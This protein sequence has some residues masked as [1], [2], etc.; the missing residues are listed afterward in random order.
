[1]PIDSTTIITRLILYVPT[2]GSGIAAGGI[3]AR[4]D[5]VHKFSRS[6]PLPRL[7]NGTYDV[8]DP[9]V[10]EIIRRIK[11]GTIPVV[12]I[13]N[14]LYLQSAIGNPYGIVRDDQLPAAYHHLR[15]QHPFHSN[16]VAPDKS[17]G[18]YIDIF[19]QRSATEPVGVA[20]TFAERESIGGY[21][22]RVRAEGWLLEPPTGTDTLY[23]NSVRYGVY[24]TYEPWTSP[25]NVETGDIEWS[26][27]HAATWLSVPPAVYATVTHVRVLQGSDY[28]GLP[29]R[30]DP[31]PDNPFIE[32]APHDVIR[33]MPTD[34]VSPREITGAGLRDLYQIGVRMDIYNTSNQVVVSGETWL[35]TATEPLIGSDAAYGLHLVPPS[36][37]SDTSIPPSSPYAY[38]LSMDTDTGDVRIDHTDRGI[39]SAD[40]AGRAACYMTFAGFT[41]TTLNSDVAINATSIVV[42]NN[43][44]LKNGDILYVEAEQMRIAAP[45]FGPTIDVTRGVNGTTAAIHLAGVDVRGTV[46]QDMLHLVYLWE[47]DNTIP[48]RCRASIVG[49]KRAG[50]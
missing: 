9:E 13:I 22:S 7:A 17:R 41:V 12:Y 21:E 11:A 40:Y 38:I 46:T 25:D 10:A 47:V 6:L 39:L 18:P 27:D 19:Y 45:V 23:W 36:G 44:G 24:S 48:L 3:D 29:V 4:I 37:L 31:D 50:R 14:D 15:N 28:I 33:P 34:G 16:Y 49:L 5:L 1:M 2:D 35:S 20:A 42:Q 43:S 26:I 8:N 32:L 30:S